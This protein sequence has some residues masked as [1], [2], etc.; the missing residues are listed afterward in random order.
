MFY[1]F[2][3]DDYYAS[4]GVEDFVASFSTMEEVN[5][6]LIHSKIS[7]DW[8]HIADADMNLVDSGRI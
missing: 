3:G 5:S 1:L 4:G 8:W 2:A 6:Y 7:A